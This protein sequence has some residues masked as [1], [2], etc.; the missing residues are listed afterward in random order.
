MSSQK[1]GL[2]QHSC[3]GT[4]DFDFKFAPKKNTSNKPGENLGAHPLSQHQASLLVD[5]LLLL[6][7]SMQ[8]CA[9]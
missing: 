6:P 7:I 5:Q 9:Q 1:N 4:S 8:L 3:L 2:F